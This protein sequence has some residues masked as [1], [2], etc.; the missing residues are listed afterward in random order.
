MAP[1]RYISWLSSACRNRGPVS[2][3][4]STSATMGAPEMMLVSSQPSVLTIGLSAIRTGYFINSL[5]SEMP[6]AR[7]AV[8]YILLTSSRSVA[9]M[10]R[11]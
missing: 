1:A 2:G 6:P 10:V 5:N 4:D 8:T 7:A 11:I 3:S 9:R